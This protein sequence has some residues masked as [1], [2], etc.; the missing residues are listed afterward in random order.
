VNAP[1]NRIL[2]V[3]D[4]EDDILLTVRAFKRFPL[5]IDMAIAR[6]G[7]EAIEY[8]VGEPDGAERR[9][10]FPDLVLLDLNLP[11]LSGLDVLRRVREHEPTRTLP[12]VM[13][14]SSDQ[15]SDMLS[16]YR[17]GANSYVR[18]P[19][20]YSRFVEVAHELGAYWLVLNTRHHSAR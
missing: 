13:L 1:A 7:V 15:E 19:V 4:N 17:L 11:R 6:D 2:L 20:D 9:R 8:L 3:E 10:P 12:V 14:T 18:K 16:S 5:P